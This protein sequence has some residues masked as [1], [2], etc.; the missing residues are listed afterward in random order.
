MSKEWSLVLNGVGMG[1]M[2]CSVVE[3][4]V[5]PSGHDPSWHAGVFA[6]LFCW[7]AVDAYR[8]SRGTGGTR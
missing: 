8:A 2:A 7:C 4:V 6:L 1:M 5:P 3:H